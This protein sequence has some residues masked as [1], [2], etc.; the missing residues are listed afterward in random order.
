MPHGGQG[1][2]HHAADVI[3]AF[4][5]G[6]A[7]AAAAVHGAQIHPARHAAGAALFG[8]DG[9]V[10]ITIQQYGPGQVGVFHR[11]AAAGQQ[12][13]LPVV[14][15][16]DGQ[17]AGDAAHVAVA[18]HRAAVDAVH[19]LAALGAVQR[20]LGH[21]LGHVA[22]AGGDLV[23]QRQEQIHG[24]V[25]LVVDRSQVRRQG[26]VGADQAA[27]EAVHLVADAA[28]VAVDGVG[29]FAHLLEPFLKFLDGHILPQLAHQVTDG[30]LGTVGVFVDAGDAVGDHVGGVGHVV[31]GAL[32]QVGQGLQLAA[33]LRYAVRPRLYGDVG[34]HLAHD[35]AHVLAALHAAGAGAAGHQAVLTAHDAAYVVP[36]MGIAHRAC[37]GA[38]LDGAGGVAGDAAHVGV[39]AGFGSLLALEQAVERALQVG[40]GGVAVGD[41]RVHGHAAGA[42]PDG[43][44]V[45]PGDA[46]G[47]GGRL[48]RAVGAALVDDAGVAVITGDAAHDVPAGDGAGEAAVPDDAVVIAGDAADV[49]L[50]PGGSHVAGD[51]EV[52]HRAALGDAAE[53]AVAGGA[54]RQLYIGD[55]VALAVKG[56]QKD[57]HG[58]GFALHVDVAVQHHRKALGPGVIGAGGGEGLQLLRSGDGQGVL[59]RQ[60][61]NAQA[62]GQQQRQQE[63]GGAAERGTLT[64]GHG[65]PPPFRCGRVS[66]FPLRHR[67]C[68]RR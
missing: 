31:G 42:A 66:A 35:A 19:G 6:V 54:V 5:Q 64:G 8:R 20:V 52:L 60:R 18:L 1:Q 58:Q 62:D 17:C 61:R 55:L 68:R 14:V 53:H 25:Q 22:A 15:V 10:V 27:G 67:R 30:G 43:A 34:D 46:A 38:V 26:L 7:P 56:A 63:G 40:G 65:R 49:R 3:A 39:G 45:L 2:A 41:L 51:G 47:G 44:V 29:A 9:A 50:G 59:C 37:V 32:R 23:N 21:V 33:Q 28:E 36:H 11:P 48:H 16:F 13:V 57:G 24:A 12:V 4:H